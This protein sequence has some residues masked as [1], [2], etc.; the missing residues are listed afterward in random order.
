MGKKI[1]AAMDAERPKFPRRRRPRTA[2]TSRRRS[3]S[4]TFST[5]SP[6][7][8]FNKVPRRAYAVVELPD[9]LAQGQPPPVEFMAG[10]MNCDIHLHRQARG[11]CRR[12]A[13][14]ASAS[15][16]CRP[17]ST[18][19]RR[20][21]R[22]RKGKVV[23]ALGALKNVGRRGDEARDRGA[24]DRPQETGP[25]PAPA[26]GRRGPPRGAGRP[27]SGPSVS[28]FDFARRGQESPPDSKNRSAS[29]ALEMLSRA[30]A[31]DVLDPNRR[32]V[33]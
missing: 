19:P 20:C 32:R 16:S 30:G 22:C 11:L 1:Q 14:G 4:G 13:P 18:A 24:P 7:Y 33:F 26:G 17:A 8:G 27:C 10:V 21:S 29:A 9:R 12:G 2:S 28:L 3:K 6:T 25:G 5:S 15:R 31:F 23:Y